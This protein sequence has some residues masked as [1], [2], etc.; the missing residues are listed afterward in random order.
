MV[1]EVWEIDCFSPL[2]IEPGL[3]EVDKWNADKC[4]HVRRFIIIFKRAEG[5]TLAA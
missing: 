4:L 3:A 2:D 1:P 5:S